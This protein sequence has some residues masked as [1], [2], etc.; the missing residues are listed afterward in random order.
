MVRLHWM[1]AKRL[2][3]ESK[4]KCRVCGRMQPFSVVVKGG[5]GVGEDTVYYW[6]EPDLCSACAGPGHRYG[7]LGEESEYP[8]ERSGEQCGK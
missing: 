4:R 7:S 1:E 5:L 2:H 3:E 8:Y 6:V